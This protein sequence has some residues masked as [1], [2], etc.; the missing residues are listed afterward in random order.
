MMCICTGFDMNPSWTSISFLG[1]T[2]LSA[3]RQSDPITWLYRR[4]TNPLLTDWFDCWVYRG[5]AVW[6]QNIRHTWS[7][8]LNGPCISHWN[9]PWQCRIDPGHTPLFYWVGLN[10]II[11]GRLRARQGRVNH[12]DPH[13]EARPHLPEKTLARKRLYQQD[14]NSTTGGE[15]PLRIFDWQAKVAFCAVFD[16]DVALW[17][18]LLSNTIGWNPNQLQYATEKQRICWEQNKRAVSLFH[19]F[20]SCHLHG[21]QALLFA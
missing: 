3:P 4:K 12:S 13:R 11:A 19:F 6:I 15:V 16:R 18:G 7:E 5:S 14:A 17:G 9:Q 8:P 1:T 20:L 2:K 21:A 10:K